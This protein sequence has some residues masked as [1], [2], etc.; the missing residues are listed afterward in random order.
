M[1]PTLPPQ[2]PGYSSTL[3]AGNMGARSNNVA[4]A[5]LV[6]SVLGLCCSP[7][8][9][10]GLVCSVIGFMQ[11]SKNPLEFSTSKV[12][13][14]IGMIVGGIALLGTIIFFATGGMAEIMRNMPR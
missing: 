9:I 5:G 10:A 3:G 13:P 2:A 1:P 6:M 8:A 12:V 14:I 7:L 4:I 11:I